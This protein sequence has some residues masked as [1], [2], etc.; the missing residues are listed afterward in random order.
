E[1]LALA[2]WAGLISVIAFPLFAAGAPLLLRG[3]ALAAAAAGAAAVLAAGAAQVG[4]GRADSARG[5]RA[6]AGTLW[7]LLLVIVALWLVSVRRVLSVSPGDL[8]SPAVG[9]VAP[10]GSWIAIDGV[11]RGRV[12]LRASLLYDVDSKRFVPV[13]TGGRSPVVFSADGSAAA[14]IAPTTVWP[15]GPQEI[16]MCRLSAPAPARVRTP[17]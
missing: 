13:G 5:N 2:V 11:A 9:A 12:D 1:L 8:L 7:S 4:F 3:L 17:V 15:D 14:W 16:W 10:S 6:R